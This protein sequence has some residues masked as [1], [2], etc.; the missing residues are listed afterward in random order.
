MAMLT[1]ELDGLSCASCVERAERGLKTV[2]GVASA[3]VNLAT[4]RATIDGDPVPGDVAAALDKAGYPARVDTASLDVVGM[5]C[6]SCTGRVERALAAVPGVLDAQANFA[7]GSATVRFLAGAAT[8]AGLAK[9]TS[10]AGYAATAPS[11]DAPRSNRGH[12][13]EGAAADIRSRTLLAALLT[14]PVFVLEMGSHA[15]PGMAEWIDG[16]IGREASWWLQ[17]LLVTL[18]LV[19]PGRVFL[20]KGIPAL[21]RGAPE[22]NSLVALGTTAAWGYSVVA[23]L[24]PGL[25][26]AGTRAVYFEAAAVIVTLIL[27]GRW[28]EARARGRTGA[29]IERLVGLRPDT[30]RVVRDGAVVEIPLDEVCTGDLVEVRPG[31]RLPVD[32]IVTEG[33]SWIDESMVTGEPDP[34]RKD[35]GAS[36]TGG[37]VNGAGALTLRAGAVG[38]ESVL[39]RIIAMVEDAQATKLPIQ[40]M[41]DRVTG[42]FVPV[43]LGLALLTAA[44]WL[45]FSPALAV[46]AG[47]S[48]LIVA[49]PCAM[50]LATP[51]S[52]M[53]GTGRAAELGVLF[54][55]G[56]AL[57]ALQGARVIALDK[58][59]TLTAGQPALTELATAPG[60]SR[61]D[62]LTL[63][64][65]A[66]ARSEHPIA[67]A[68]LRAAEA[69]GL[70]LPPAVG[71]E[72]RTGLGV[73][74]EVEGRRVLVG[75]ERFLAGEGI[76]LAPLRNRADV[77]AAGGRTP[78]WL[79]V[80]G[81]VVA[82]IGVDDP[83]KP[84]TPD[85]IAAF[86][87]MGLR[88]AMITGDAE[89]T[90]N[91]V[92]TRLDIDHVVAEVLPGGKVEAVRKL[93]DAYG[94]VAFVGDGINDAPALAEADIGLAIGTGTD[95]AIEAAD[96]VLMAGELDA[97][98]RAL[99]VSRATMRNIR[100]NLFWAFVYNAALIP[101][102]A[103][104]LYPVTGSLLSPMLAAGA[105]ALSSVFVLTNA[106]RL[107][108]A[109]ADAI[110]APAHAPTV[111]KEAVA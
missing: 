37:T 91:A 15:V 42:V 28:L 85:A 89:T 54:R 98:V 87:Q 5:S 75:A 77:I 57:Q 1:F 46:V 17:A 81:S 41:V 59:G 79:A 34:V 56:D 47:V 109:S 38:T 9:A 103:G 108:R 52:I 6:A 83:L 19:W 99:S 62:A 12:D 58:T 18:V 63:A 60:W 25:F 90:A 36:V 16:T 10:D 93:R 35:V 13:H 49:C 26:P 96:V 44:I 76:D 65:A 11:N 27:L 51:T 3:S 69:D 53:V 105:M 2:A 32:G 48:V 70:A 111:G 61:S 21:M 102:A 80:D 97:V 66:E 78:L 7:T 100:Q 110:D 33:Q 72:S 20:A 82:A 30:A 73:I 50:G 88:V 68:I 101:V 8:P 71:F 64:A 84:S 23:L 45:F 55:R 31:E 40:A 95:I 67:R 104:V 39:S 106:L 14:L 24:A 43:V 29:A 74:A 107:R 86:H 92:A 22:M 94:P 4:G